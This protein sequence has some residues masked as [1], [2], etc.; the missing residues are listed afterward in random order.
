MPNV[1][2]SRGGEPRTAIRAREK[3]A[4][5][6]R[7]VSQPA[8][9][10][11]AGARPNVLGGIGGFVWLA[12][13]ILPIYY[14]VITSLRPQAGFFASNQ[15]IPPLNPTLDQYA[16]VL[17]SN[18]FLYL[19]NSVIITLTTVVATVFISLMAAFAIVHSNTKFARASF[20]LFLL[21]LAIPIQATIIPLFYMLSKIGFYDSLLALIMPSIGFALPITVLILTNFIRDIPKEL[22][23]SM[24]LDGAGNWRMLFSLVMPLSRPA[25]VTVGLYDALHVWN[26]FLFPLVLTQSPD[27]RVLPLSLWT[28]QGEFNVNIPALL[29]AVVLATLPIFVLYIFGRRQL[30]AG[31]TAGFNK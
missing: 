30:I 24:R 31:L 25:I 27:K 26:G 9:R 29:A 4:R 22:F 14:I 16:L 6:L 12:I 18:F 19:A 20:T 5:Q 17:Q 3:D 11:R 8:K 1:V 10:A 13:I 28:F 23:E 2:D 15:L 21:G 7:K